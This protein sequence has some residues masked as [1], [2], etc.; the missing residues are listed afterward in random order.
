MR[1]RSRWA[2]LR[3]RAIP[4]VEGCLTW[5][6]HCRRLKA[7]I[8]MP[9][10]YAAASAAGRRPWQARRRGWR[11]AR[12][13][14]ETGCGGRRAG[15][16]SASVEEGIKALQLYS[17]EVS[18]RLLDFVKSRAAAAKAA[19]AAAPSEGDA[20]A[21]SSESEVVDPQPAE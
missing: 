5:L 9:A 16:A 6:P 2:Y 18:S 7:Y 11:A 12:R 10:T 3:P 14:A 13:T 17:K 4:A 19:A 20:P 15:A 1:P 21:A 8:S